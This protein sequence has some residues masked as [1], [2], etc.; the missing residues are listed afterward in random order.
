MALRRD[1]RLIGLSLTLVIGVVPLLFAGGFGQSK[2]SASASGGAADPTVMVRHTAKYGNI[3]T[4]SKGKTLYIFE[5]DSKG[6]SRCSGPCAQLW[7]PLLVPAGQTPSGGSKV[8]GSL[9]TIKRRT[10]KLQV[11]Y[12]GMPLYYFV[13]DS[14]PGSTQGQAFNSFGAKWYVVPTGAKTLA[15][16]KTM[17]TNHGG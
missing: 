4:G 13:Y 7:P 12:N 10:G 14:S 9:G 1:I 5:K 11:T 8:T 3:L 15:Q 6:K 2:A 16:A 17:S